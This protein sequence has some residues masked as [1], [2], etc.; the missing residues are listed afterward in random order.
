LSLSNARALLLARTGDEVDED[1]ELAQ[2]DSKRFD[3]HSKSLIG[4]KK[5]RQLT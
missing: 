2:A 4:E 3:Q 5:G 1:D